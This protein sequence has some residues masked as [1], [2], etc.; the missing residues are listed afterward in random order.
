MLC[1]CVI[2]KK[3][4][5]MQNLGIPGLDYSRIIHWFTLDSLPPFRKQGCNLHFYVFELLIICGTVGESQ[6][7]AFC[8]N[9]SFLS[10]QICGERVCII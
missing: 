8:L 4:N 3:L 5:V 9:T 2:R 7:S 1:I 10:P 6:D